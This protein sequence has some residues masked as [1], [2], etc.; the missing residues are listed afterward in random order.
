M[1]EF[2]SSGKLWLSFFGRVSV[3]AGE[4]SFSHELTS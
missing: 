2:W 3:F 1:V 4:F